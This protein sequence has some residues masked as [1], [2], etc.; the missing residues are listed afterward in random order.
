MNKI[1]NW[2]NNMMQPYTYMSYPRDN[3]NYNVHILG[4]VADFMLGKKE[5]G[6]RC[7]A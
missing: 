5:R 7:H 3:P 2:Q 4:G 6:G 1:V